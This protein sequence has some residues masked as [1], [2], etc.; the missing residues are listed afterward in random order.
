MTAPMNATPLPPPPLPPPCSSS[1]SSAS[2][3]AAPAAAAAAAAAVELFAAG[4]VDRSSEWSSP[5][6][7]AAMVCGPPSVYPAYG[8]NPLAWA[9]VGYGENH[10]REFLIFW[11]DQCVHVEKVRIWE[12][13]CPGGVVRLSVAE[14]PSADFSLPVE[15]DA[16]GWAPLPK[17]KPILPEESFTTIWSG[18]AEDAPRQARI[19]EP[20]LHVK[21]VKAQILRIEMDFSQFTDWYEM[22]AVSICGPPVTVELSAMAVDEPAEATEKAVGQWVTEVLDYSTE[23]GNPGWAAFQVVGPP[24]VFPALIDSADS[25][26]PLE[27]NNGAEYLVVRVDRPVRIEQVLV[28][29]TL[30][31]GAI[32]RIS[33][34]PLTHIEAVESGVLGGPAKPQAIA[35]SYR[36]SAWI[37]ATAS[38]GTPRGLPAAGWELLWSAPTQ[39]Q[40][41]TAARI[42]QPQLH[43]N[44]VVSQVVKIEL[45]TY[46]ASY[47]PEIDAVQ[48]RGYP[49]SSDQPFDD[50]HHIYPVLHSPTQSISCRLQ[51]SSPIC[52]LPEYCLSSI[53]SHLPL[54]SLARLSQACKVL[55]T[56][57][58]SDHFFTSRISRLRILAIDPDIAPLFGNY[59]VDGP[60]A[61]QLERQPTFTSHELLKA[62]GEAMLFRPS[63]ALCLH[64][65]SGGTCACPPGAD[66]GRPSVGPRVEMPQMLGFEVFGP[67]FTVDLWFR[68]AAAEPEGLKLNGKT[69][70]EA[71]RGIGGTL[72]GYQSSAITQ[73]GERDASTFRWS[74]FCL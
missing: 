50:L 59:A 60:P 27:Y 47:W 7:S 19:F 9:P 4:V 52:R 74:V 56:V 23:Y 10:S 28:W 18:A 32:V 46:G 64:S 55:N 20:E 66:L 43:R 53:A 71:Q 6:W 73:F 35:T 3:G 61:E 8:D 29:E 40:Q 14:L 65:G 1:S 12:T 17:P 31:P 21:G 34:L 11:F 37:Q 48:I 16:S 25:W 24:N 70:S 30:T 49:I 15:A 2:S 26:T 39:Y 51:H 54:S 36:G 62:F 5:D 69:P 57:L 67:E 42:F 33:A 38:S 58:R 63:L 68:V 72:F 41:Q 44:D 45:N 13:N 22:D